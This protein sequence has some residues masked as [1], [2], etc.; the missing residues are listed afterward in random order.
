MRDRV[1][2]FV[3]TS[4]ADFRP[5]WRISL[6]CGSAAARV[7]GKALLETPAENRRTEAAGVAASL[8][9]QRKFDAI[10][11]DAAADRP[12]D[13]GNGNWKGFETAATVLYAAGGA[14]RIGGALLYLDGRAH[15]GEARS[16]TVGSVSLQPLL[17]PRRAGA[18]LSVGF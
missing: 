5:L 4:G 6:D 18:T 15:R 1:R 16:T 10:N 12:Y 8:I 13:P 9:A 14:A 11:A 2:G 17:A 7:S 3:L